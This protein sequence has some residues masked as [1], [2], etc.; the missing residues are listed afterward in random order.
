MMNSVLHVEPT[1]W[2]DI[3][4]VFLLNRRKIPSMNGMTT[5]MISITTDKIKIG[6]FI[7][8]IILWL[9]TEGYEEFVGW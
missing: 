2:L 4:G 1:F 6:L 8:I 9:C 7:A 5:A 3:S